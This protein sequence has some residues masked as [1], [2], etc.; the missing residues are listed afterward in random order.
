MLFA[1]APD[2]VLFAGQPAD[3]SLKNGVLRVAPSRELV[4]SQI[5]T[6]GPRQFTIELLPS[7]GLANPDRPGARHPL[8]G[9]LVPALVQA[10]RFVSTWGRSIR[11]LAVLTSSLTSSAT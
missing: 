1:A 3:V 8:T 11:R 4:W 7:L 2:S 10:A 9:H 5:C 6:L